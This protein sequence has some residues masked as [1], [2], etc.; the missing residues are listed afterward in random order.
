[1]IRIT[2]LCKRRG[3]RLALDG[4]TAT[5]ANGEAVAILGSSGSGKTTLLRCLNGLD[6][7]DEGTVDIAGFSLT[8]GHERHGNKKLL[9]LQRSVGFVFQ[10]LH[11]FS[12]LSVL[13][14]IVLAPCVTGRA[15]LKEA[16]R[17]A[18]DLLDRVGL[19]DRAHA[20]PHELSGGQ[21]QRV[22]IARALAPRPRVLLL[23]EPTSALDPRTAASVADTI[24]ELTRGNVTLVV[25][26]HQVELAARLS[27]R[28]LYLEQ[29][30]LSE[31]AGPGSSG[32]GARGAA[33]Q[34]GSADSGP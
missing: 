4:V 33:E 17:D 26:T 6:G 21:K 31:R 19:G 15:T 13:K 14:N 5:V 27:D 28:V 32:G 7:F 34:G 1:M 30:V 2:N 10:E 11:L 12:H 8:R 16:T 18:L 22:A 29:G 3:D 25:V 23:D 9:E 20:L 24:V